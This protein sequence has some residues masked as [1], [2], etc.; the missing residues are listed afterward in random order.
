MVKTEA[1]IE[2]LPDDPVELKRIIHKYQSELTD[3]RGDIIRL[4]ETIKIYQFKLFGRKSENLPKEE[5]PGL[6]NE[7]EIEENGI[8]AEEGVEKIKVVYERLKKR[9]KRPLPPDLPRVEKVIDLKDEEKVCTCCGEELTKFGEETSEKLEIIPQQVYVI[10]YIRPKYSC[11]KC[12]DKDSKVITAPLPA[13][14]IPQGIGTASSAAF[15]FKSKFADALPYYR[16]ERIFESLGIDLS[17]KTMCN[18][19]IYIYYNYLVRLIDLMKRD[20]KESYLIGADETSVEVIVEKGKPPGGKSYMW[21]YRG[22]QEGKTILLFDYEPNRK[23]INPKEYLEGYEGYLQTD[24]YD[25]YNLVVKT[26]KIGHLTCW[27]HVRRKFYNCFKVLGKNNY[28]ESKVIL[29][30]IQVLYGIEKKIKERQLTYD[31]I[32]KLRQKESKPIIDKIKV[33]LDANESKYPPKTD[34]GE[35][36]NYALNMWDKLIVYLEDGRL[37]IDNNLVENA[38]RPF[39]IGRKNWLFSYSENG[40][41]SSA[42]IYSLI[43]TAKAN[44]KDPYKYLKELFEKL[45]SAKTDEDYATLLPYYGSGL[46]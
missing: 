26:Q 5:Q 1:N 33:W 27:A 46:F 10:K 13:M 25:G 6:F 18:W 35:A 28:P 11:K 38:I 34:M 12:K 41:N 32:Y 39:V 42:A 7:S 9:G 43:E 24:G 23:G 21:V 37:P 16:Q 8:K 3:L 36:I 4:T 15:V 14:L 44:G 29:D 2:I 30:M 22:Y 19:Q 40:A 31:E 20:L 45:P 17:R